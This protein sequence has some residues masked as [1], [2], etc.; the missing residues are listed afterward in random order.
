MLC[1]N[2]LVGR[3][4]RGTLIAGS[5]DRFARCVRRLEGPDGGGRAALRGRQRRHRPPLRRRLPVL[6]RRRRRRVRLRRRRAQR[7]VLRR[8]QRA[9]RAL[10]QRQPDRAARCGSPQLPSPV[11]DLTAVTG[12]YP[13]DIDSDGHIDLAVLRVGEDVVLRGLGDCRFER[14]NEALG[15]DGG[16]AWTAAF[17]ATWEGDERRC[18]RWRSAT[19]SRPTASRARTAG[20]SG[21]MPTAARY[22]APIA[23][24]PGYCTLSMLFSDWSRSGQRDLRMTNDRHYYRDGDGAAV[25]HR[26]RRGAARCTPRPTAGGRCRSGAWASPARTSPATATPRCS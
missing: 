25:A 20:C 14:A 17:S 21:P 5:T 13:L 22:A 24:A 23:L 10:P 15:I 6:R 19:T 26:A 11:T 2:R 9:G 16:D 12:A 8:R 4:G 7:A 3:L 1:F 18:R